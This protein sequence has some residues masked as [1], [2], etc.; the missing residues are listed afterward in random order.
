MANTILMVSLNILKTSS[1][2]LL[3]AGVRWQ[4]FR[5]QG[6]EPSAD[7]QH[8]HGQLLQLRHQQVPR[9]LS[10]EGRAFFKISTY[11]YLHTGKD[12]D[13]PVHIQLQGA[14]SGE[15]QLGAASSVGGFQGEATDCQQGRKKVTNK[16]FVN[17]VLPWM[18]ILTSSRKATKDTENFET[19]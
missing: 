18:A 8:V 7:H 5:D 6:R 17:I 15:P 16:S 19:L 13:V 11:A 12:E 10:A 14:Q 2:A 1:S 4:R 9:L 3:V